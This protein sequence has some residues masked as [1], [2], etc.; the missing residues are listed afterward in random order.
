[1]LF[2]PAPRDRDAAESMFRLKRWFGSGAA[3]I[4][5]GAVGLLWFGSVL[6]A[7]VLVPLSVVLAYL[8]SGVVVEA[9]GRAAAVIHAP[10]GKST[11][12]ARGWSREEALVLQDRVAEAAAL[13]EEATFEDPTHERNPSRHSMSPCLPVDMSG[14]TTT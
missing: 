11:P 12:P 14:L 5:G 2:R 7:L 3:G 8:V 9:A 13:Y 4:I 10:S 1:M 6:G